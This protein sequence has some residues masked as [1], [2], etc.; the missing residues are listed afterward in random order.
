MQSSSIKIY[1]DQDVTNAVAN[2]LKRRE[3]QAWTTPERGNR[4][5][6]DKEQIDFATEQEAALLTHNVEDFPRLHY[7]FIRNDKDHAGII[8]AKQAPVGSIVKSLLTLASE[9]DSEDMKNR[10]EYLSNWS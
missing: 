9:H 6:T 3:I 8:V 1:T 10:L 2:A 4:G 7:E 5:L